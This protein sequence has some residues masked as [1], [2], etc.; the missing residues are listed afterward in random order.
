MGL[1]FPSRTQEQAL[2]GFQHSERACFHKQISTIPLLARAPL[3]SPA[4]RLR[5]AL[6]N[7][8]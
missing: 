7:D 8:A 3:A 5:S 6:A 1:G 4:A 2:S